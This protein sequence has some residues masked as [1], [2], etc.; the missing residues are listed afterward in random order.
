MDKFISNKGA[1]QKALEMR[2]KE[3]ENNDKIRLLKIQN[4]V[5]NLKN[6]M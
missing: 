5:S 1:F 6:T 4:K 3:K 2:L